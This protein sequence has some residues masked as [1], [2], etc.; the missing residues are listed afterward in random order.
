MAE[1]SRGG[2]RKKM[3]GCSGDTL[4]RDALKRAESAVCGRV[5][6]CRRGQ[7]RGR[8]ELELCG[9]ESFDNGHRSAA[10]GTAPQRVHCR[11]GRG[12]RF[13]FRWSGVEGVEAPW[14]QGGASS[15]GEEAEVA[16]ADEALG[17]QMKEEATEKLIAR[18]G[19]H[20][21]SIVVGGVTP[22]KGNLAVRQCDQAMVGDG[23]AMSIAA[24]ILQH[25]LGSAEG[26]FGVDDPVFAEERTQPGSEEL[27]MG[28]RCEFSG[29]VQLT[30]F[31]GRL[32]SSH[33]LAAKHAPQ[34]SNGKEETWVGANPAGVIAGES[35]GGNDTVDMR[36]KLEFLVPGVKHAEEADLG[37]EMGGGARDFQ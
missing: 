23:D 17:E 24:E 18:D 26:W 31:E 32:Q 3:S 6:S 15:V 9:C 37:T 13:V 27:G 28:E 1:V 16:D 21:L 25:V 14:Q 12:F 8:T 22:A 35:A 29:Q 11:S 2:D 4:R 36:M 19:H 10:L 5:I 20:F 33:E 34:H 7:E 30:A